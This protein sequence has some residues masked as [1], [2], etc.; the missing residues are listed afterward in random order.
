ACKVRKVHNG[1]VISVIDT[2]TGISEA[3]QS[4]V[5]EK[6]KQVGDTLTDK[7]KGTGLGL[8]ICKQI[9]E[10][11]GGRIWVESEWGKGSNFSFSLPSRTGMGVGMK[12]IDIDILVKQLKVH[13]ETTTPSLTEH[14]KTIL[15]VDDDASI[16]ELL[17]QVFETSGYQVKLAEDGIEAIKQVKAERPDL[18]VLDVMMPGVSGFDVVAMLKNDPQTVDIPIIILSIIEDQERGYRLG[19]DQYFIK[20]INMEKLLRE[21]DVLLSRGTSKK[22]VLVMD[23]NESTMKTLVEV[24]KAKGYSVAEASNGAEF[25]EKAL[26][27]KPDMIIVDTLVSDHRELIKTLRFEKGLENVFF[28]LISG[29]EEMRGGEGKVDGSDKS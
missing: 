7:P 4:T 29:G 17:K 26:S 9:I 1:I 13:V 21:A 10:H 5:F 28:F 11:H 25:V 3:D 19:V 20:P 15:V 16:R 22:K 6:F 14:K 12:P 24:L 2:G 18:I 27:V 8:P 23:E